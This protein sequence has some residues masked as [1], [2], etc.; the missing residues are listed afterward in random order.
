MYEAFDSY[1]NVDTWHT[2]HDLDERR[3]FQSLSQVVRDDDFSPDEMGSYMLSAK[4]V[5]RDNEDDAYFVHTI[6][7][8]VLQA[9]AIRDFL[10][11]GL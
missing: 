4:V 8:R 10:K 2:N 11:L 9:W 6:D 1:L 5:N 3:F 7:R